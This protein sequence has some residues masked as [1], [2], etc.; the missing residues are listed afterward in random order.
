HADTGEW[1]GTGTEVS[2]QWERCN[3]TGG[4]CADI[5]GSTGSDFELDE[6]DVGATLRLRVG[7]SNE[8]GSLTAVS[9]ATEASTA[10]SSLVNTWA[11]SIAGVLRSGHAV[12]AE[13]GSWLGEAA[14]SYTYQWQS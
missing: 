12:T 9:Q 8:L 6:A 13:A 10:A 5:A 4:E 2:Y 1:G 14:I 3:S 7:A 11:P